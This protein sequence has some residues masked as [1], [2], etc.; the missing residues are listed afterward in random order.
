MIK[1]TDYA[2]SHQNLLCCGILI[3]GIL[4]TKFQVGK[5]N[6]HAFEVGGLAVNAG[7]ESTAS[8]V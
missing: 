4:E 1:Q 5:V 8:G 3:S 6:S 7:C 2:P